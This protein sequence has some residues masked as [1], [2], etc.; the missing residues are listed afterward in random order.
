LEDVLSARAI[1]YLE[2]FICRAKSLT[3]L[4]IYCKVDEDTPV[5]CV[6]QSIMDDPS[7]FYMCLGS[8][9]SLETLAI[10]PYFVE[11]ELF[12][13][14]GDLPQLKTLAIENPDS[15]TAAMTLT[16]SGVRV[17]KFPVLSQFMA[18]TLIA[19]LERVLT[20]YFAK[21]VSSGF[22]I[23]TLHLGIHDLKLTS[24]MLSFL[25]IG[26]ESIEELQLNFRLRLTNPLTFSHLQQL[27]PLKLL[28][29]LFIIHPQYLSV[30]SSQLKEVT[31]HWTN[32]QELALIREDEPHPDMTPKQLRTYSET[33]LDLSCLGILADSLPRLRQLRISFLAC[34]TAQLGTGQSRF[35][36]L[37]SLFCSAILMNWCRPGF[38]HQSAAN[39]LSGLL[40]SN[41]QISIEPADV[42][43]RGRKWTRYFKDYRFF[44][45][46]FEQMVMEQIKKRR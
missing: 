20:S 44:I 42:T 7:D 3:T 13:V 25:N 45:Q 6:Q 39:Y 11:T 33:G 34:D 38:H 37:E 41:T 8:F 36:S 43:D 5:P 32:L 35:Y 18:E 28:S 30:E 1:S 15:Y 14:I 10:D 21:S 22:S 2:L 4:A 19:A 9:T 46:S 16:K 27:T 31:V 29:S 12:D 23:K 26:A 40:P 24:D 17:G